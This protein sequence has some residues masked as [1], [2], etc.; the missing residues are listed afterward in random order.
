M[1]KQT[2]QRGR[3]RAIP[4]LTRGVREPRAVTRPALVVAIRILVASGRERGLAVVQAAVATG[5]EELSE[6]FHR[7]ERNEVAVHLDFPVGQFERPSLVMFV[8]VAAEAIA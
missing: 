2:G 8:V 6:L 4:A 3:A 5:C 1:G 7:R